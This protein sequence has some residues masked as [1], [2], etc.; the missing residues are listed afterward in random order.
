MPVSRKWKKVQEKLTSS[1]NSKAGSLLT[2]GA[3]EI[4]HAPVLHCSGIPFVDNSNQSGYNLWIANE[5]DTQKHCLFPL[6]LKVQS[7]KDEVF[8]AHEDAEVI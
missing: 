6:I 1:P 2:G 4:H 5:I 8:T 7:E 3:V